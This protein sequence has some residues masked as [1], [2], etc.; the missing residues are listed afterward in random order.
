LGASQSIC[1]LPFWS[2][3]PFLF[4]LVVFFDVEA[5][6][7]FKLDSVRAHKSLAIKYCLIQLLGD[8][9]NSV[10]EKEAWVNAG[11]FPHS[12]SSSMT[13]PVLG[14]HCGQRRVYSQLSRCSLLQQYWSK[15]RMLSQTCHEGG[16]S[17]WHV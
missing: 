10:D 8:G 13:V 16:E 3:G 4:V 5:T 1:L 14:S 17:R 15:V 11:S 6:N 2:L 9:A 7:V 12:M